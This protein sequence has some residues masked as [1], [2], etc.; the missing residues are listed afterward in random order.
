MRPWSDYN[1]LN[2]SKS[3]FS[4]KVSTNI[5]ERNLKEICVYMEVNDSFSECLKYLI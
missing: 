1:G 2:T 5:E 3:L 4:V